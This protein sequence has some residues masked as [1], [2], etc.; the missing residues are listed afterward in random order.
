MVIRRAR[1]QVLRG[2]TKEARSEGA[3]N[4]LSMNST[5]RSR[6][7]LPLR[8]SLLRLYLLILLVVSTASFTSTSSAIV[9]ADEEASSE[10][11]E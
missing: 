1:I 3:A 5:Y 2:P 9:M 8:H 11:E 7:F 6:L 10:E 4:S